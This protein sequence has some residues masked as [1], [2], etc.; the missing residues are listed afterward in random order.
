M[1]RHHRLHKQLIVFKYFIHQITLTFVVLFIAKIRKYAASNT[2]YAIASYFKS[3]K[4]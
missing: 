4:V 2:Y 3:P 1:K